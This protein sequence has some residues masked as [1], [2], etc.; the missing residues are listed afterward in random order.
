M[1]IPFVLEYVQHTIVEY[2]CQFIAFRTDNFPANLYAM[3]FAVYSQR[4]IADVRFYG[5]CVDCT[6]YFSVHVGAVEV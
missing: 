6:G 3:F 2:L 5:M 1:Y 4:G